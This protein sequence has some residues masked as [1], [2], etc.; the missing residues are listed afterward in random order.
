[1]IL[2]QARHILI[3]SIIAVVTAFAV[4]I[5][6]CGSVFAEHLI[7]KDTPSLS[8]DYSNVNLSETKTKADAYFELAQRTD[9]NTK[10]AKYLQKSASEYYILVSASP[11]DIDACIRLARVYDMQSRDNY[12]K[13]YF[14]HALGLN[15]KSPE[16][17]YYLGDFYYK[18]KKYIKALEYYDKAFRYGISP[19]A[20]KYKQLGMVYEHLGDSVRATNYYKRAANFKPINIKG[21]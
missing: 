19:D 11:D 3:F 2:S 12:A 9:S 15:A 21:E 7:E 20:E 14:Y 10:R 18:R 5:Y 1:M 6:S 4:T 13:S 8:V 17:N 16:A